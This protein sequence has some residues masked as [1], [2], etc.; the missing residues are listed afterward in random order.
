MSIDKDDNLKKLKK[1]FL[2]TLQGIENKSK[3]K[4]EKNK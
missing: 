4:F 3:D 1:F 2:Q